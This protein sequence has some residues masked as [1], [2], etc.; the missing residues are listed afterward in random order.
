VSEILIAE[1][2]AHPYVC[3]LG[4]CPPRRSWC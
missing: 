3:S 2:L 4:R 1:G